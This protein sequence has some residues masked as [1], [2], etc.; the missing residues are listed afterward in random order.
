MTEHRASGDDACVRRVLTLST[1]LVLALIP[2]C[3]CTR[4]A[5]DPAGS[6]PSAGAPGRPEDGVVALLEF[7]ETPEGDGWAPRAW[8][9]YEFENVG[10]PTVYGECIEDGRPALRGHSRAGASAL[11]RRVSLLPSRN[12]VIEWTW[13]V[14]SS[15]PGAD[16]TRKETDDCAARVLLL[17]RYEPGRA[18]FTER[19][20]FEGAKAARGEY[21]PSA[22]LVYAWADSKAPAKPYPSP[23]SDRIRIIAVER[24]A[25]RARAWVTERRDHVADFKEAFGREPPPLDSVAFMVDTDNTGTEA[26]GWLRSIRFLPPSAPDAVSPADASSRK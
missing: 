23:Y 6:T 16:C 2:G 12:P 18:S 15:I 24:G 17:Y 4:S 22:I 19:L 25:E 3:G 9:A 10:R 11:R 1:L 14:S 26:T 13:R 21:P 5:E 8:E 20:E 7:R